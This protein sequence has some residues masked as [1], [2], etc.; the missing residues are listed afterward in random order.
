MFDG[1]IEK[2]FEEA[3]S[4]DDRRVPV[5]H[6]FPHYV[7]VNREWGTDVQGLE[8]FNQISEI[9]ELHEY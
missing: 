3:L 7:L 5:S 6:F 8:H 1:L 2:L 4:V 9:R